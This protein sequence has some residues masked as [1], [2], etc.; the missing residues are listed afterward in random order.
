MSLARL[1][2]TLV[3]NAIDPN[4]V[5]Q[6]TVDL[7][8]A[9]AAALSE[10][11]DAYGGVILG[12]EVGAGKTFV[13]FAVLA[14]TLLR[15]PDRGAVI[16]V[17][18]NPLQRKWEQQAKD[19]F[20]AAVI[21]REAGGKLADRVVVM[22]RAMQVDRG[23]GQQRPRKTDI[24]IAQH[25]TFSR[26]TSDWDRARC[27]DRWLE[28]RCQRTR[29][30]RGKF[31]DACGLDRYQTDW[32]TWSD[33]DVLTSRVL[34]PLDAVFAQWEAGERD[35]RA[36]MRRAVLDIRRN[37][38]RRIL[39]D[40]ALAVIDE[41]HNLRSTNSQVYQSLMYVLRE[42]ID[43]MLFLTAT[44]FQ[45]GREELRNVVEFFR[46]ASAGSRSSQAFDERVARMNAGMNGYVSALDAFGSAWRDLSVPEVDDAVRAIA[47][48]EFD[49]TTLS[50]ARCRAAATSFRDAL[51]EAA[52]RRWSAAVR[53]PLGAR[54]AP[55]RARGRRDD[56][57]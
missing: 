40:A 22:N 15:N 25:S 37:V 8:L 20:R 54:P 27:V 57:G 43:A 1:R 49:G 24:V 47:I 48:S 4:A 39:P 11:L 41:A 21:D 35:L 3:H 31:F 34:A 42:R 52:P 30:P 36:S 50:T 29:K 26:Q 28:L 2:R 10:R 38:G 44:P 53:C 51:D 6:A 19:Y 7:Q 12:D 9:T 56:S 13:T 33:D 32:W 55:L 45:L 14:D 46:T 18:S 17:P 23:G 5:S 16:F